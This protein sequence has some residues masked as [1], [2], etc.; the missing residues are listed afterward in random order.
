M[1]EEQTLPMLIKEEMEEKELEVKVKEEKGKVMPCIA[2]SSTGGQTLFTSRSNQ[3]E[4]VNPTPK[5]ALQC[6][7]TPPPLHQFIGTILHTQQ[8][9]PPTFPPTAQ[10]YSQSSS[11]F[12]IP[13]PCSG[14]MPRSQWVLS[15]HVTP[16]AQL[17]CPSSD[18]KAAWS[19]PASWNF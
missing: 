12:F 7:D 2:G 1:K 16:G 6:P 8:H 10:H 13:P 4:R 5:P 11:P 9:S 17:W 14:L 15:G 19:L 18:P 3:P